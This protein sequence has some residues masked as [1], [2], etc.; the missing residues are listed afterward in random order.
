MS[1]FRTSLIALLLLAPACGGSASDGLGP[2]SDTSLGFRGKWIGKWGNGVASPSNDYTLIANADHSLTVY[3]GLEGQGS[4]ATGIW[5]LD[6]GAFI[7][8]YAYAPG[9]TLFVTGALANNGARIQGNWG[10]G[11]STQGTYWADKR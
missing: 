1:A 2:S 10:R 7:G 6:D 3:D 5:T 9:D 8:K 4:V 11:A